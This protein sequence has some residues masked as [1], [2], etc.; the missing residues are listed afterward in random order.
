MKQYWKDKAKKSENRTESSAKN[1]RSAAEMPS[2]NFY[3]EQNITHVDLSR[4][5]SQ[6][7]T[8]AKPNPKT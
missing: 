5:K 8:W 3:D 7:V 2:S 1:V 6:V 4:D